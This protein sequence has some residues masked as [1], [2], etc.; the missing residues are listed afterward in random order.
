MSNSEQESVNL[1]VSKMNIYAG[2][3]N[4]VVN[5]SASNSQTSSSDRCPSLLLGE[6]LLAPKKSKLL[7]IVVMSICRWVYNT[8][9]HEWC[10]CL[11]TVGG[12]A[13]KYRVYAPTNNHTL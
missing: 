7:I 13:T 10:A 1:T 5:I 12:K 9:D 2:T 6:T 3:F 11:F 8:V 4:I